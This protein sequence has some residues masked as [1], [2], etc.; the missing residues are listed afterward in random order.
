MRDQDE[1]RLWAALCERFHEIR[2]RAYACGLEQKWRTLA[3]TEPESPGLLA[4]W[5]DLMHE[6]E[7]LDKSQAD[8]AVRRGED[9]EDAAAEDG[10]DE[11][12]WEG[13]VDPGARFEC[14]VDRCGRTATHG[15]LRPRCWLF[16]RDMAAA[17]GDDGSHDAR[18]D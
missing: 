4:D 1:T 3:G 13:W 8:W 15:L 14:P 5:L 6:I 9:D 18:S 7:H 10:A 16:D 11:D 17:R 12:W 2:Q